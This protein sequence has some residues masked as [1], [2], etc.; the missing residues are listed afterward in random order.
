MS[1][2]G[3][4]FYSRGIADLKRFGMYREELKSLLVELRTEQVM[5]INSIKMLL[6]GV[7]RQQELQDFLDR[8]CGPRWKDPKFDQKL[9][10]RLG[11]AHSCFL[12]TISQMNEAVDLFKRRLE[13]DPEGKVDLVLTWSPTN[14]DRSQATFHRGTRVQ[15][16]S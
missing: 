13:L 16:A 2:N 1:I 12:D 6:I 15:K 9:E 3:T 14:A 5:C 10:E 4:M 11:S 8:P 7:V